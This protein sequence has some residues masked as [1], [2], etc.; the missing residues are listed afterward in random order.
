MNPSRRLGILGGMFD[1]VHYGH[2]NTGVAAQGALDLTGLLVVPS[3][4]PP[5]R[6]QPVAT[7]FHRFAMVAMAVAEHP[8]WRALDLELGRVT[9]SFTSDTLRHLHSVGCRPTELFSVA[10]QTEFSTLRTGRA[11]PALLDLAH[12]AVVARP[13]AAVGEL[14]DRLPTLASRMRSVASP[15]VRLTAEATVRLKPDTTYEPTVHGSTVRLQPDTAYDQGRAEPGSSPGQSVIA[16][17]EPDPTNRQP[18]R[19]AKSDAINPAGTGHWFDEADRTHAERTRRS[20]AGHHL[21]RSDVDFF[22]RC[23][24]WSCVI[25]QSDRRASTVDNRRM[26]P[27]V[28]QHIEQHALYEAPALTASGDRLDPPRGQGGCMAKLRNVTNRSD[29]P[30]RSRTSPP[31]TRR[32]STL[33]PTGESGWVC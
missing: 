19:R 5:H 6:A 8:G 3:N 28:Q 7:G 12:F 2:L 20:A 24:D 22:D 17:A 33:R 26:V 25:L 31:P 4:N 11:S 14:P 13:G 32:R 18:I 16:Y 10:A 23:D 9:H 15:T 1:P 30:K 27:S 21:R 29:F